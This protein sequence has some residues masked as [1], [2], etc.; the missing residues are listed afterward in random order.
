M[1][2][3]DK[4]VGVVQRRRRQPAGFLVQPVAPKLHSKF[5][6]FLDFIHNNVQRHTDPSVISRVKM[7]EADT[8]IIPFG[9]KPNEE[10]SVLVK[11]NLHSCREL[12]WLVLSLTRAL[13]FSCNFLLLETVDINCF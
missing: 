2:A 8:Q 5:I 3:T 11:C 9:F 12:Q 1:S 10:I 13:G 6:S 7:S 4:L